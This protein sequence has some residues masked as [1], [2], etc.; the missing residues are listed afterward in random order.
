MTKKHEIEIELLPA[1]EGDCLLITIINED[2]HILIDGGTAN[3]YRTYLRE[4]LIQLRNDGKA[5]DLLV[6]TH[7]DNDHI[8]GIIE[9]LKENGSNE[10]PHI[11]EIRNIWHNSYRHL[12]FDKKDALGKKKKY[13]K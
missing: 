1:N 13:F 5:I 6:V 3:T 12:Q 4:R 11:I 7:I 9:L 10:N 8:G 2:I